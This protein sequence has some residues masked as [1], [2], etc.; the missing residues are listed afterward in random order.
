M[1]QG[2]SQLTKQTNHYKNP[3]VRV[4]HNFVLPYLPISIK[5]FGLGRASS[6][7]GREK[8]RTPSL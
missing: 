4:A 7:L 2:A 1:S 8:K 5:R 3:I 6:F